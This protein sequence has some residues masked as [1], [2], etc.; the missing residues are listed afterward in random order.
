MTR[1]GTNHSCQLILGTIFAPPRFQ[2]DHSEQD[3]SGE[4]TAMLCK[5]AHPEIIFLA[6][7][8]FFCL[9]RTLR[10]A[11]LDPG[12]GLNTILAITYCLK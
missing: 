12:V 10:G 1:D 3:F 8:S 4:L 2:L 6:H 9:E 7:A 5:I 11:G